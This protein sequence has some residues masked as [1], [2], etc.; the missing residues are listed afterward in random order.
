MVGKA[1]CGTRI[2]I[3]P[4]WQNYAYDKCVAGFQDIMADCIDPK[5]PSYKAT[6]GGKQGGSRNEH[7]GKTDFGAAID[8]NAPT[9][10]VSSVRCAF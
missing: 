2:C 1:E 5:A 6:K 3:P 10:S 7:R 4:D 9:W 8:P